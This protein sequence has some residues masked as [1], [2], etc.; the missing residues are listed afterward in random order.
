MEYYRD[1]SDTL[2]RVYISEA[3]ISVWNI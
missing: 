1:G 3:N 2:I